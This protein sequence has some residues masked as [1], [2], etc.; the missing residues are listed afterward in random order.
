[1]KPEGYVLYTYAAIQAWKDAVETAKTTDAPAVIKALDAGTFQTVIGNI[2]FDDKGDVTL[3]GY[4]M[5]K[6]SKGTYDYA[7]K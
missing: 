1:V 7:A 2:D 3:P 4:V 5:Y 6:W